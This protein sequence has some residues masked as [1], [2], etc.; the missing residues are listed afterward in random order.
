[1]KDT[2]NYILETSF[3]LFL[4]KSF[5]EVTMSEIVKTTGLSKGAFYHYFNSKEQLFNEIIDNY[6]LTFF[7]ID[8]SQFS[9]ESLFDFYHDYFNYIENGL[10]AMAAEFGTDQEMNAFNYYLLVFDA[11]RLY[12]GFR[13]KTIEMTDHEMRSWMTVVKKA[14]ENGEI[15]SPMTDEQI[16]KVFTSSNDGIGLHAIMQGRFDKMVDEI[17]SVFDGFYGGLK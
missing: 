2:K 17:R 12:P 14:R 4:Q 3:R 10:A 6:Y 5:K 8:Y 7:Q 9:Q 15:H 16:A 11:I 1:M 13:Q